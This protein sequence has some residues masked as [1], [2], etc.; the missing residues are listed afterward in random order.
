MP[1]SGFFA[2]LKEAWQHADT[3]QRIW[4]LAIPM[5]LSNLT[6]PLVTLVDTAVVGRLPHAYQL[7]AVAAGGAVFTTL[8]WVFGF[9]RMGATGFAAQAAGRQDH[10]QL[11]QIFY[12]GLLLAGLL[13]ILLISA[14]RP[15]FQL[16]IAQMHVSAELQ[17]HAYAYF[18]VRLWGLPAVLATFAL[19]GW[20]IGLQN[21]KA[22]LM[23][24]LLS[25]LINIV[26]D[27][28]F[29]FILDWGVAGAA[30]ASVIA[31][32]AGLALG[33]YLAYAVLGRHSVNSGW[34]GLAKWQN[35]RPLLAVNRD[36]LIRSLL[37]Q[38]VFLLITV[39][40]GRFGDATVSANAL[41]LN[42]LMLC[43]FALDGLA[44]ALESLTGNA[45]G[46]KNQQALRRAL[47]LTASYALL[48][49]LLFMLFFIL[50][51]DLF[52]R[53]QT[54]I[55]PVFIAAKPFLPYLA[56]LPLIA[57][58]SY[59]LD[60]L[61]IGA[62]KAKEMRN[63]MLLA[64]VVSVPVGY[65]LQPLANHGLWLTFLLFMALRAVFLLIPAR[66]IARWFSE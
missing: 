36:I 55:E 64:V 21:A 40:G 45:L 8:A 48:A 66:H 18:S 50:F 23:M 44:H 2:A 19:T 41:L 49:S 62:T 46:A 31:E 4:A 57:V 59:I 22:A 33:L 47:L 63:A 24:S 65:I 27:V 29:V 42:G 15:L 14:A 3:R 54:D 11:K 51:G 37:L 53:L 7:G 28:Y 10:A 26:L 16:I 9:L 52:I 34:Q 1:I 32:W 25:N 6:V 58:W 17:N 38:G 56:F 13:A 5:I 61:F 39:Q 30:R 12:Q 43:S 60:G 35:W 20:F